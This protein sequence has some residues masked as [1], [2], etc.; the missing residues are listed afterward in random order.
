MD[1]AKMA[2][3]VRY[4]VN[5]ARARKGLQRLDFDRNCVIEARSNARWMLS[6]RRFVHRDDYEC[7]ENA[8]FGENIIIL[9]RH[10]AKTPKSAAGSMVRVWMNSPGHRENI[11]NRDYGRIGMGFAYARNGNIWASQVFGLGP[12][13]RVRTGKSLIQRIMGAFR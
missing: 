2:Q 12:I 1:N 11:L 4:F 8:E 13:I 9:P 10:M 3:Y 6:N 5:R 7:N